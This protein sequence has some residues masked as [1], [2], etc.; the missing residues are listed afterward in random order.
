MIDLDYIQEEML[1]IAIKFDE[2]CEINQL[3]YSISGG[4]LIG[5]VRHQGFIPWDD[6]FDVVM[7]RRDFDKF[8]QLWPSS[9]FYQLITTKDDSYYKVGTPAKLYDPTTRVA[10]INE[11]E[12]GMPEYN[13]YGLFLD[14]FPMDIYPKS[15][16]GKLANRYWGYVVLTKA[17]S[18]F[19]MRNR[20]LGQ[21]LIFRMVGLIP[22]ILVNKINNKLVNW[23]KQFESKTGDDFFVG[24]GVETPFHNLIIRPEQMWPAKKDF[25]IHGHT[26]KGPNDHI[27]YLTCRFGDF[28]KLPPE[29]ARFQHIINVKKVN[30]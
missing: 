6:D 17:L 28:M 30:K 27:A 7:P 14:I 22:K 25:D 24:Y 8:V 16:L 21:R 12:N 15:R 3:D 26:F 2:F 11:K 19:S 23:L 18:Q 29:N 10:E 9:E 4:S 13:P 20:S 1:K 5:A